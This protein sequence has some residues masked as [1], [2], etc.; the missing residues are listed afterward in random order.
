VH[1]QAIHN[2]PTMMYPNKASRLYD[3]VQHY[4]RSGRP[5]SANGE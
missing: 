4:G 3:V 1:E 2:R 5:G